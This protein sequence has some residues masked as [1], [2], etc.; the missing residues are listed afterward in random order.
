MFRQLVTPGHP[1]GALTPDIKHN[2]NSLFA[3]HPLQ[4]S[5]IVETVWL[6]RYHAAPSAISSPFVPWPREI[7]YPI[8]N[9]DF[10][11]GYKWSGGGATPLHSDLPF[12]LS[13]QI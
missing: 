5:A 6:N 12:P 11:S 3:Y 10:F 1:G 8:L 13:G 4:I 7:T 9:A 2:I